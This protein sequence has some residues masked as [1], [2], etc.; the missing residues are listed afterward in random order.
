MMQTLERDLIDR[1]AD[2][3]I[4]PAE[5]RR[6]I[7]LI[8]S[9]RSDLLASVMDGKLSVHRALQIVR[10]STRGAAPPRLRN[11][12]QPGGEGAST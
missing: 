9:G 7:S 4:E 8:R 6:A 1:L 2:R 10:T 3:G 12:D 5:I 11:S